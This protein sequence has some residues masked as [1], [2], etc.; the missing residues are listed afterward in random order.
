LGIIVQEEKTLYRRRKA[1]INLPRRLLDPVCPF[2]PFSPR[3]G[4]PV[5]DTLILSN[6]N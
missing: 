4:Y 1:G 5:M 3:T 2:V 6:D